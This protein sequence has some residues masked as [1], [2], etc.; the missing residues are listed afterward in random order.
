[1]TTRDRRTTLGA[2]LL[3][4]TLLASCGA[5]TGLLI[6]DASRDPDAG[7]DAG[8]DAGMC[9]PRPVA[10]ERRGAQI[11]FV[12]DRSNSMDDTL[13]GRVPEP[14]EL[15]RW[16]LLAQTLESVLSGA[17]PLLELGA[18]FYPRAIPGASTP[19]EACSVDT[20]IDLAPA[21]GNAGEL[22]DFFTSTQP[23]GGTP[24]ALGLEEARAFFE[25]RPD[26]RLPR[27]VVLATDGGPNCNPDTGIPV[28]TCV[29]TD[30]RPRACVLDPVVGPYNCLDEVRTLD[31]VRG[32]ATDL[33]IPVYVI[34]MDDPTRPDL[35]DVLDRMAV[36][37]DRPREEPGERRFYSVRRPDDLRGA[38]TTITESVSRCV[39]NVAPVP[40]PTDAVEL[41]V[42]GLFVPRDP[43]RSE[44]WD[45]TTSSRSELTLFGGTCERVTRTGAEVI[46]EIVCPP[47]DEE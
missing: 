43:T 13:D 16:D 28:E 9:M 32:L 31:A 30:S 29:C 19:E 39:F 44:G 6:P 15:R 12:I 14:G 35:A 45:F 24:T 21:R 27:Y 22:L 5:K 1:M 36:A 10:L 18:E 3:F 26:L 7:T 4:A 33:G 20:G 11:M 23:A 42:D 2:S 25:R 46:A 40:A 41:R 37:G 8:I 38:L 34:G 47:S 17:D